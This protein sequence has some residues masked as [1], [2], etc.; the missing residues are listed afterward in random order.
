MS[1]SLYEILT[2]Y[3]V[4]ESLLKYLSPLQFSHLS[5]VN[6]EINQAMTDRCRHLPGPE[7]EESKRVCR[8]EADANR[9]KRPCLRPRSAYWKNSLRL[10]LGSGACGSVD[11]KEHSDCEALARLAGDID[12][13]AFR[14]CVHC[15]QE[16]CSQCKTGSDI[17]GKR[18][19]RRLICGTC[20]STG[21][22]RTPGVLSKEEGGP[23][24]RCKRYFVIGQ[25]CSGELIQ[26]SK[27]E[28][29]ESDLCDICEGYDYESWRYRY[30]TICNLPEP[31]V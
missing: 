22:G 28:M 9:E 27:E 8:A 29:W 14:M 21:R 2:Q 19:T 31:T 7:L 25:C 5:I 23:T 24:C 4:R 11:R 26:P 15:R 10:T 20:H 1:S 16:V 17:E 30:C 13:P 6:S 12:E 3:P 18:K